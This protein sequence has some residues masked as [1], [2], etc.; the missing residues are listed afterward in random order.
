MRWLVTGAEGMLG[1]DLVALLTQRGHQVTGA[2]RGE[3]DITDEAACLRATRGHDVVANCAAY[4]AVDAAEDDEPAAYA[5]NAVGVANL[6]KSVAAHG[7]SLVQV[8]TDYVFPGTASSPYAVDAPVGPTLAYGRTKL[9][10]EWAA[11]ALCPRT[12]VIRVAWLYGERGPCFPQTIARLLRERGSV[13]VV[14]DEVGQPTWTVDVADAIERLATAEA[15]YGA[16]HAT[17]GGSA[18]W[19]DLARAVADS[20]GLDPAAV[21]PTTAA[22][23]ARKAARPTYS[24]LAHDRWVEAGL[25]APRSWSAAWAQAAPSVLSLDAGS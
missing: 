17:N 23:F 19:F 14:T 1:T 5:V 6:A 3:L 9:A 11:L 24:V 25:S 20:L 22:A 12:W 4:T 10:G 16:W 2:G 21:Q 18:T 8:S 15:P 7:G 13:S